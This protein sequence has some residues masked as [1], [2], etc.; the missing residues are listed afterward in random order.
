MK[1][2][3]NYSHLFIE[4][5]QMKLILELLIFALPVIIA[6]I[7][8]MVI[9]KFDF[10]K[11]LKYPIDHNRK[12]RGKRVFG[13]NKTYRGLVVMILFSIIFTFLY[14]LLLDNSPNFASYNL[15][16]FKNF[17]FVFYG[18][19]YGF[20]YIIAELPNSFIKRQIGS[21]EGKS[22]SIIM[23]LA[24]QL[25]SVIGIMLLFLPF[26][27]FTFLHFFVGIIFFGLLHISI[28]YLLFHLGL[29]KEPF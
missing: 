25:D 21:E 23:I 24:D 20:G 17:N 22:E 3:K 12:W 10:L 14:K 8:H 9:V 18:F 28:N 4:Y 7:L 15:L 2:L 26:S 5:T 1:K 16:N 19:L 13:N 11:F 6:A 29:R 27:N